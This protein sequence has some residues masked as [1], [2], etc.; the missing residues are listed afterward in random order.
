MHT[1]WQT[2]VIAAAVR[3]LRWLWRMEGKPPVGQHSAWS[4]EKGLLQ[5]QLVGRLGGDQ[6]YRS[7]M[8]SLNAPLCKAKPCSS[9]GSAVSQKEALFSLARVTERR[10]LSLSL[11]LMLLALATC[12]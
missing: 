7:E 3:S 12:S 1:L 2:S 4:M 10:M 11:A 8:A 6:L 9:I 5:L